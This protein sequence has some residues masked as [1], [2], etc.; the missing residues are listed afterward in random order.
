MNAVTETKARD[1]MLDVYRSSDNEFVMTARLST[2][3]QIY[4]L[5]RPVLEAI[6]AS[7][8]EGHSHPLLKHPAY[9][10]KHVMVERN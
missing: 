3:A 1:P 4:T 9:V 5:H 6:R 8:G 10:T 7:I 2:V